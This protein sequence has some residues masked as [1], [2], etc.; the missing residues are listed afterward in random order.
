MLRKRAASRKKFGTGV[1]TL[2]RNNFLRKWL[3]AVGMEERT[4]ANWKWLGLRVPIH[5]IL[6][7]IRWPAWTWYTLMMRACEEEG[8]HFNTLAS[9][10]LVG[11][12]TVAALFFGATFGALLGFPDPSNGTLAWA[13]E[14]F[15]FLCGLSSICNLIVVI[16]LSTLLEPLIRGLGTD[17]R[18]GQ[19]L[20]AYF[21]APYYMFMDAIFLTGTYALYFATLLGTV[22]KLAT[23]EHGRIVY[24]KSISALAFAGLGFAGW[25][26]ACVYGTHTWKSLDPIS[27]YNLGLTKDN[28]EALTAAND[29]REYEE[30][31]LKGGEKREVAAEHMLQLIHQQQMEVLELKH[32]QQIEAA[33][34]K[35]DQQYTQL[36]SA[37]KRFAV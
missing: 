9:E 18:T 2:E 17:T 21:G 6:V 29:I 33:A 22:L 19:R 11:Q 12:T 7:S 5:M 24:L 28:T 34:A 15:T 30:M 31:I 35:A 26:C 16:L 3:D 13:D 20:D 10:R 23:F 4:H 37:G 1:T 14:W 32:K 36:D 27:A 25:A 8:E